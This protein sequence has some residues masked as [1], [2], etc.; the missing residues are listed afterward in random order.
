[1]KYHL[2]LVAVACALALSACGNNK[3]SDGSPAP[4]PTPTPQA[5]AIVGYTQQLAATAPDDTESN[6]VDGTEVDLAEDSEPTNL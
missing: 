1:M 3:A 4:V 2:S 5:N 6:E